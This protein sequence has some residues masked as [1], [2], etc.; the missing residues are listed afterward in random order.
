MEENTE[1]RVDLTLFSEKIQELKDR[2]ASVIVGQ[3]Q[4]VDLVLTAIL[5]NGHVLIEGVPGVAKTLSSRP[6]LRKGRMSF[7]FSSP[8]ITHT[9]KHSPTSSRG[10]A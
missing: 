3:E 2:I 7:S 4:T 5:A 6:A 1:Q 8:S 10:S 9:P